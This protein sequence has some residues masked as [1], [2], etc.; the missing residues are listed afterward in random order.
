METL[1]VANEELEHKLNY[2]RANEANLKK[3]LEVEKREKENKWKEELE[4]IRALEEKVQQRERTS[5][6]E[7]G[8]QTPFGILSTNRESAAVKTEKEGV[9]QST[10]TTTPPAVADQTRQPPTIESNEKEINALE[11]IIQLLKA[12]L[13]N[14]RNEKDA[15]RQQYIKLNKDYIELERHNGTLHERC[16]LKEQERSTLESK[17]RVYEPSLMLSDH[18]N[19]NHR[20]DDDG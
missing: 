12:Q 4:E 17:L 7:V 16:F 10:Q 5:T 3:R 11:E 1:K 8:T 15:L 20:E 6:V 18:D 2:A 13:A 9:H 14:V 19:T